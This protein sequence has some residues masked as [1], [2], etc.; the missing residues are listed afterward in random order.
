[1]AQEKISWEER[2][3]NFTQAEVMCPACGDMKV[4]DEAMYALQALRSLLGKPL[5]INSGYRSPAY[6]RLIGGAPRSKHVEGTAFDISLRNHDKYELY[7]AAKDVGF[8]GF[9]F[10]NSFL[11]VDLGPARTW[12]SW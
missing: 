1:M 11:H 4:K 9:G 5:T 6:N 8:K 10:Y 7:A 2:Y 12:G 3:P